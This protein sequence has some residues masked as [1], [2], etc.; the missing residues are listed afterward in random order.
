VIPSITVSNGFKENIYSD[1][2]STSTLFLSLSVGTQCDRAILLNSYP[3]INKYDFFQQNF[4]ITKAIKAYFKNGGK[5]LYILSM[6]WKKS[7]LED[8][9]KLQEYMAKRCDNL[10]DLETICLI[11]IFDTDYKDKFDLDL[12]KKIQYSLISYCHN[13][14]KIFLLD[15]PQDISDYQSYI[16]IFNN[17]NIYYPWLVSGSGV[18]PSSVYASAIMSKVANEL[19]ISN[20]I[21]NIE[22]KDCIDLAIDTTDINDELYKNNINPIISITNN[23]NRIWG[24]KSIDGDSVNTTRVLKYIKRVLLKNS[25]QYIFEP[26]NQHLRDKVLRQTNNFLFYIYKT[27]ALKGAT[28]AEAFKIVCDDSNNSQK[29]IENGILNIDIYVAIAKTLEYIH[30]RL[31]RVQNETNQ[32]SLNIF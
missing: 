23:G 17:T 24:V 6:P 9:L 26:N 7:V 19:N 4:T 28:Q 12:I 27:G 31:N 1:Y 18:L 22:L 5:K 3:D 15:L 30:I 32:A 21:A 11:D 20:S 25:K 13:I 2:S 16:S 8:S 29:D 10:Y 14:H